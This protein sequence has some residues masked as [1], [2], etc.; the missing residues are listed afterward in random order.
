MAD[1]K[2]GLEG[3]EE[4][5]RMMN[6]IAERAAERSA[7]LVAA[8]VR[9][10][11]KDMESRLRRELSDDLNRSLKEHLGMTPKEHAIAHSRMET[12]LNSLPSISW[13]RLVL[14]SISVAVLVIAGVKPEVISSL[15]NSVGG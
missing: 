10:E 1:R 2:W 12:F 6:E 7:E 14:L 3:A 15:V 11:M 9:L 8:E 13:M 4:W 5:L